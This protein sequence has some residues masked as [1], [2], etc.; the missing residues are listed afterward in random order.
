MSADF[1]VERLNDTRVRA[2]VPRV[3]VEEVADQERW[4]AHLD[5]ALE[6]GE[7]LHAD[8]DVVLGHPDNPMTWDDMEGK[9]VGLVQPVL[10]TE[11]L[12]LLRALRDLEKSG[13]LAEVMR[14]VSRSP[15][16]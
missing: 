2:I 1:S 15:S 10:G 4:A 11:T 7:Q 12:S 16:T 3:E 6:G 13:Q 14:L 8:Q 5:V 9:F